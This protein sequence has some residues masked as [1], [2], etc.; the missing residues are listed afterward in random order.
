MMASAH[1]FGTSAPAL[2]DSGSKLRAIIPLP[3]FDLGM[4]AEQ[5]PVAT[6][7]YTRTASR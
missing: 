7:R 2:T 4:L 5:R 3:A 1:R 6:V